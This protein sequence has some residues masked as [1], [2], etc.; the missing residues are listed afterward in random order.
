MC[1]DL[2]HCPQGG[3]HRGYRWAGLPARGYSTLPAVFWTWTAEEAATVEAWAS[4]WHRPV[5]GG[6][7]QLAAHLDDE[8]PVTRR[9]DERFAAVG[10][11]AA[12]DRE[13]LVALQPI[14][15]RRAVWEALARQ[16]EAAPATWRWWIRRHPSS[17]VFQDAEHDSLRALRRPNVVVDEACELPLPALLRHVSVTVS[18]A[19]GAATEAAAFGVPSLFVDSE[20]LAL[21]PRLLAG[22]EAEL[23]DVAEVVA[24]I[25]ALPARPERAVS[26]RPPPISETLQRLDRMAADY[27]VLC[28]TEAPSL[29]H[30]EKQRP[31]IGHRATRA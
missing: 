31:Q 9:W 18:L 1:V 20:A 26:V 22:G 3:A 7:S 15:G 29:V 19:S 24:C 25:A 16:I 5:Y 17:T 10:D 6:H 14:G 8:D 11:P 27:R 30:A 23:I 13:I 4:P 28:R 2:Q 21:F 12:Y